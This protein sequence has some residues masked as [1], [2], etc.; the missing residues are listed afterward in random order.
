MKKASTPYKLLLNLFRAAV[1]TVALL[2]LLRYADEI[3]IA[4]LDQEIILTE[5][6]WTGFRILFLFLSAIPL[7]FT[8]HEY[9]PPAQRQTVKDRETVP[10]LRQSFVETMR[11]P[12]FYADL[13]LFLLPPLFL[14]A[15]DSIGAY[16]FYPT[17]LPTIASFGLGMM[18]WILPMMPILWLGS[19]VIRQSWIRLYL[20]QGQRGKRAILS[21]AKTKGGYSLIRFLINIVGTVAGLTW[22][23]YLFMMAFPVLVVVGKL[24]LEL[25]LQIIVLIV[26]IYLFRCFSLLRRRKRFAARMRA[27][28]DQRDY[29][30]TVLPRRFGWRLTFSGRE[31]YRVEAEGKIYSLCMLRV[32][33]SFSQIYFD[34]D[35]GYRYRI[36]LLR[37]RL[38]MPHRKLPT[39]RIGDGSGERIVLLTREPSVFAYGSREKKD[40]KQLFNGVRL[41]GFSIYTASA[42][43]NHIDRLSIDSR[44]KESL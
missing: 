16:L 14:G 41:N 7:W 23:P 5:R 2:A 44:G 36:R 26:A 11:S 10:K 21:G 42:F 37:F 34:P 39:E 32:A 20:V 13:L 38:F 1:Y 25:Y 27:I 33:H 9:N 18:L 6:E 31:E 4:L 29:S 8:F 12:T 22:A 24:I 17:K 19:S 35:G 40:F 30:F 28:C 3:S 43:C 15:A